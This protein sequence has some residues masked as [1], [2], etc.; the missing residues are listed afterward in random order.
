M[1]GAVGQAARPSP[2][3]RLVLAAAR[4]RWP[5]PSGCRRNRRS[6]Y[7]RPVRS[8]IAAAAC[9]RL[10]SGWTVVGSRTHHTAAAPG[11]SGRAGSAGSSA[12]VPPSAPAASV[13]RRATASCTEA[14]L[15]WVRCARTRF[16]ASAPTFVGEA[17]S[18][19]SCSD[20][21]I[22]AMLSRVIRPEGTAAIWSG[23]RPSTAG[24]AA[25]RPRRRSGAGPRRRRQPPSYSTSHDRSAVDHV[26][27]PA[28]SD[29]G[30]TEQLGHLNTDVTGLGVQR[31][32]AGKDQIERPLPADRGREHPRRD[33]CV[34][35]GQ[36]R[37]GDEHAPRWRRRRPSRAASRGA[38]RAHREDHDL[39]GLPASSTARAFARRQNA[40][41]STPTPSR[42]RRPRR[43]GHRDQCVLPPGQRQGRP[44][45]G[46]GRRG[47]GLLD[48][49]ARRRRDAAGDDRLRRQPRR[50]R[51]R[52]G[53][54]RK[55]HPDHGAVLAAA[56]RRR[57]RSIWWPARTRWTRDRSRRHPVGRD[58]RAAFVGPCRTLDVIDGVAVATSSTR[59]ATS[60]P[61]SCWPWASAAERLCPP[62]KGSPRTRP[63]RYPVT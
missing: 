46:R 39:A 5:G 59:A 37:I 14:P 27:R 58:P 53:A 4:S 25:R 40:F 42:T 31:V 17:S 10:I 12:A 22:S 21:P 51:H 56:V 41:V 2:P 61:R 43:R 35:S 54:G 49:P 19:T 1:R 50:A 47:R 33:Q 60:M 3:A 45:R 16:C 20:R 8:A 38:G 15:C 44:A 11:S 24:A 9:A 62:S 13:S 28:R 29:E 34:A 63:P 7:G 48:G 23:R 26:Q 36:R 55:R 52:S 18:P 30:H 57:G 6:D 32:R